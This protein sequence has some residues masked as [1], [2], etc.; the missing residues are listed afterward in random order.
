M[1]DARGGRVLVVD[2]DP[3]VSDVVCRWLTEEDCACVCAASGEEAW[4]LLQDGGFPLILT[5]IMMPGMSGIELLAKVKAWRKD[6][7]VVML[8]GVDDREV[9]IHALELGA[10]AYLIKPF[11]KNEVLISVRNALTRRDLEMAR[12]RYEQRLEDEV[13][14]RTAEVR[15]THAE[16]TFRLTTATEYRDPDTGMHIRR[17]GLFAAR[18]AEAC[19]WGPRQIGDLRLAAPMHDVGKI[20]IPDA[21]LF[22]PAKLTVAEFEIVKKHTMIGAGLLDGSGIPLL[23]MARDIARSH[24]EKWDG[25]GYPDGLSGQ[26]IPESAR[27]VAVVD[28]Y[29]ALTSDRPYRRAMPEQEALALMTEGRGHHFDPNLFD[30]FLKLLP[31]FREM[32][33]QVA[34]GS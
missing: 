29:D 5:D 17:I 20:G 3:F 31:S 4:D 9:A 18:M 10:Y 6:I 8:T 7:A 26:S 16:I 14:A 13:R 30:T 2:D 33:E 34:K 24:H 11:E 1:S 27:I 32:R 12:D 23:N 28:V 22:K 25:S 21:I 15:R 19:G